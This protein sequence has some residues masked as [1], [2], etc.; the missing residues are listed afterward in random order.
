VGEV[1][2]TLV[3]SYNRGHGLAVIDDIALHHNGDDAI[4]KKSTLFANVLVAG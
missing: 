4:R 2:A 1:V 3:L